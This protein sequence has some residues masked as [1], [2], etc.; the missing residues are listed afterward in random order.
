MRPFTPC[1]TASPQFFVAITGIPW[2]IASN[3]VTP[4]PSESVGKTKTIGRFVQCGY[5]VTGDGAYERHIR[6]SASHRLLGYGD[7]PCNHKPHP[8]R[9]KHSGRFNE[10]LNSFS[11]HYLSEPEDRLL[12]GTGRFGG[13]GERDIKG[14]RQD[15][16]SPPVLPGG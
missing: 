16:S 4:K 8:L 5:A 10:V 12:G 9:L 2:A 6:G 11:Q 3:C 1:S 7:G 14:K 15:R 13:R